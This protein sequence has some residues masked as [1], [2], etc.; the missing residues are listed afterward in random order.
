M[1]SKE[2]DASRHISKI[3][4]NIFPGNRGIPL[5]APH[6]SGNEIKYLEECITCG[7]VSSVGEFVDKFQEKLCQFSGARFCVPVNTGTSAL[8]LVLK[9]S[10]VGPGDFVICPDLTFVA[11]AAAIIYCGATPI[12]LDVEEDTLGLGASAVQHFIEK[13]TQTVE[14]GTILFQGGKISACIVMHNIGIPA[15]IHQLQSLLKKYNINLIEDAAESLGSTIDGKMC[16][17]F[18]LAG[19]YSFNG[20]KIITTGGGGAIVTDN[21]EIYKTCKHLS[22]TAKV[23]HE[24]QYIHDQIGYNYRMP[25]LN[26][27]LGLAQLEQLDSFLETK[28]QQ[29][30]LL[31]EMLKHPDISAVLPPIGKCNH[32]FFPVKITGL[33]L[34]QTISHLKEFGIMARPLWSQISRMPPYLSCPKGNNL[35]SKKLSESI[36]CLPNGIPQ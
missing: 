10:G 29:S 1:E 31:I 16:G 30:Q 28:A 27:A 4:R 11:T 26:A 21:E 32:W 2:L 19:I 9:A 14:N 23:P 20:N 3:Y 35:I 8:H 7:W 34:E 5:H 24:Y 18:G 6:F 12:F 36:L 17:T 25:N 33:N 22:T 15:R 13:S